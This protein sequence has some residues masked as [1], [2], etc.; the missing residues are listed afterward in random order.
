MD[1]WYHK[2]LL[3]QPRWRAHTHTH[4]HTPVSLWRRL[5]S[6]LFHFLLLFYAN[7]YPPA[8]AVTDF[9]HWFLFFFLFPVGRR[10]R[11]HSSSLRGIEIDIVPTL[12]VFT[13]SRLCVRVFSPSETNNKYIVELIIRLRARTHKRGQSIKKFNI[14]SNW[15]RWWWH[16]VQ[17][18]W[19][20]RR[21]IWSGQ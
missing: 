5:V 13:F 1:G 21:S 9:G 19:R 11:Q 14:K 17:L 2:L 20:R 15:R 7:Q 8:S 10:R 12:L 6:Q 4:T 16:S 3:V 18:R